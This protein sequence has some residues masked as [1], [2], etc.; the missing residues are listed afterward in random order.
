MVPIHSDKSPHYL[1]KSARR[2]VPKLGKQLATARGTDSAPLIACEL[3]RGNIA[4]DSAAH[5]IGVAEFGEGEVTVITIH[6]VDSELEHR[7]LARA[8]QHG[9]SVEAE[10]RNI[11][12]EALCEGE[13]T[14]APTN[15]YAAVRAI[16][17]PL[18]GIEFDIS[19][20]RT[21]RET[22]RFE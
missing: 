16:V 14:P 18:G 8:A 19:R 11:L 5:Y 2:L 4:S 22:P 6:D 9:Q 15:L 1:N 13:S 12:R 20:R 10:V 7:L 17:E 3:C 21:I